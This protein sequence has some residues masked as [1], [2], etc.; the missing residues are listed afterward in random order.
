VKAGEI[1]TFA[2]REGAKAQW[3]KG[4]GMNEADALTLFGTHSSEAYGKSDATAPVVNGRCDYVVVCKVIA[5]VRRSA[6]IDE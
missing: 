6:E 1:V 3:A 5:V 2:H 4:D